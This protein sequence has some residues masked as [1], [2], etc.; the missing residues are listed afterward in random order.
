MKQALAEK[1][2]ISQWGQNKSR[3]VLISKKRK[4]PQFC[5]TIAQK[6]GL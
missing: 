3:I 1:I 6:F 4:F 5:S 2:P